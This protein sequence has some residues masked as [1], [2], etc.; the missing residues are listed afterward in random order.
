MHEQLNLSP[1]IIQNSVIQIVSHTANLI[2]R[3][4]KRSV[5]QNIARLA[6]AR[7]ILFHPVKISTLP[8]NWRPRPRFRVVLTDQAARVHTT[9]PPVTPS[10]ARY[11]R[12]RDTSRACKFADGSRSRSGKNR[13]PRLRESSP[14]GDLQQSRA[15]GAT[16]D[17]PK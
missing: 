16:F 15:R 7:Q 14:P 17:E 8:I 1:T 9:Q 12:L 10:Y 3:S 13:A 6:P 11:F 4:P 5:H 2:V